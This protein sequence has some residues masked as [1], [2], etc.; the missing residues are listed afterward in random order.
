M[1]IYAVFLSL[2][3]T[4]LTSQL[5]LATSKN[6]L[7]NDCQSALKTKYGSESLVRLKRTKTYKGT[8]TLTFKVVPEGGS[9]TTMKCVYSGS[10]DLAITDSSGKLST[11]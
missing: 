10:G 3:L 4:S 11:S 5:S 1:K 2:F 8:T 6:E 9:R 7:L